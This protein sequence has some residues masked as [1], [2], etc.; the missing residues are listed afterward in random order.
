M[1]VN[2]VYPANLFNFLIG[3][4][5]HNRKVFVNISSGAADRAIEHWGLYCSSKA[6][7][8]M[9]FSVLAEEF[10]NSENSNFFSIDPGVLDTEMQQHIRQSNF[11]EQKYFRSLQHDNKLISTNDAAFKIL[12]ETGFF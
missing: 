2:V 6:F 3:A 5:R 8:K 9:Y 10:K 11:P 1:Q 12:T 7:M 4:F